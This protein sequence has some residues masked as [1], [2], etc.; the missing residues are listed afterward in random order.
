M[1][2]VHYHERL[3]HLCT[4]HQLP[5]TLGDGARCWLTHT[6]QIQTKVVAKTSPPTGVHHPSE[7]R[8]ESATVGVRD[9]DFEDLAAK[10]LDLLS[11]AV[12]R[13]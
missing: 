1:P 4:R 13:T 6:Q 7:R 11:L 2:G 8:S 3:P 5:D 10:A 12:R 9:D